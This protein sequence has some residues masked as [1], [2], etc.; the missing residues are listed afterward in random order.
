M[1][2]ISNLV[3]IC[4]STYT[5][6]QIL[7]MESKILL[8][9]KFDFL[10]ISSFSY[11]ETIKR[12]TFLKDKDEFLGRYLLE[13]FL[14]DVSTRKYSELTIASAVIFFIQKLRGYD[15]KKEQKVSEITGVSEKELRSCAREICNM[16]QKIS[17]VN[18]MASLRQKYMRPEFM[19]VAKIRLSEKNDK[20]NKLNPLSLHS[21][22]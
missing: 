1:P 4:D 22:N 12:H 20:T 14:F 8:E 16:W 15:L 17:E 3:Y 21:T 11:Y 9:M 19:E 10:K 5:D 18:E 2:K 6:Q 13:G 7:D